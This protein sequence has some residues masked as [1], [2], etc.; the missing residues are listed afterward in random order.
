MSRPLRVK[1]LAS[2]RL[3]N[4]ILERHG[5]DQGDIFKPIHRDVL[6]EIVGDVEEVVVR[7]KYG[8]IL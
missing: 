4:D 7:D 6:A 5:G 8:I 3:Y 2:R 1:D